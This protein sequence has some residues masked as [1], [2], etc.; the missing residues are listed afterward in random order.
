[1]KK[2]IIIILIFAIVSFSITGILIYLKNNNVEVLEN[3][4]SDFTKITWI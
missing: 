2:Y 4:K 3:I 1:M